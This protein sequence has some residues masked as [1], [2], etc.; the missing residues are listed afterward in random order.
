VGNDDG[1]ND[2]K[3][4]G[5]G[6]VRVM[7]AVGSGKHQVRL[8]TYHFERLLEEACPNHAYPVKHKLRDCGIMKNFMVS[9]FLNQGMEL[10]EVPN[11]DDVIPF[12]GE[13]AVVTIYDG[14][15]CWG[16]AVCLT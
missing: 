10:D 16:C 5:P 4:G 13:D 8:P 14:R 7:T 6:M 9:G 1:G 2:E 3:A 15:P 11:E 12:L